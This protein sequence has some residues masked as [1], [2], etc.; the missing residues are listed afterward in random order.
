[1]KAALFFIPPCNLRLFRFPCC[2][3]AD[4]LPLCERRPGREFIPPGAF[5]RI[6]GF[7]RLWRR[8]VF[9]RGQ[10]FS[11][12][13]CRGT[14]S[15]DCGGEQGRGREIIRGA[16]KSL[17]TASRAR[18]GIRF[19]R[20]ECDK[21]ALPGEQRGT[22]ISVFVCGERSDHLKIASAMRSSLL[23][24]ILILN[25]SSSVHGF[26]TYFLSSSGEMTPRFAI[27]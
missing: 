10:R 5:V 16:G 21:N 7:S 11:V 2:G 9:V 14:H 25:N 20:A 22:L 23:F 24:F 8:S 18:V 6:W 1:M 15:G 19:Y 26:R 27:L 12:F 4:F 17:K 3:V 13:V